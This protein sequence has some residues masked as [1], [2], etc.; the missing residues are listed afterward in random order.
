MSADY[1]GS[2]PEQAANPA[3]RTGLG[4][5]CSAYSSL[6]NGNYLMAYYG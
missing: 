2:A 1:R 4:I 6:E 3:V 5:Y